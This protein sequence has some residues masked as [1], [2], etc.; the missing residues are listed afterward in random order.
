M[1]D[2]SLHDL[3]E[4][5]MAGEPPIGPVTP[6]A[7]RVGLRLRRRRAA[8]IAGGVVVAAAIALAVPAVTAPSHTVP[9]RPPAGHGPI[10]A[11]MG[12][13]GDRPRQLAFSPDGTILATAD[14]DGTVRLWSVATHRQI[15]R[16]IRAQGQVLSVA[17]SPDG[18][19]LASGDR[20]SVVQLWK[21]AT[22]RQIGAAMYTGEA[23]ITQLAF[24]PD[25]KILATVDELH[26]ALWNVATQRQTGRPIRA[27]V[28]AVAFS[29]DGKLLAGACNENGIIRVWSVA[30]HHRIGTTM[31]AGMTDA[32]GV[33]F[34]PSGKTLV[35]TDTDGTIRQWSVATHHQ[36]RAPIITKGHPPPEFLVAALSPDGTILATTQSDGPA[37]LWNLAAPPQP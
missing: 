32:Y 15:G 31:S 28:L 21:V 17:F 29:P 2:R 27:I 14:T 6:N 33:A 34:T 8:G 18:T 3:L 26:V 25:G 4:D 7:L 37:R 35:T 1:D 16:P 9:D 12:G 19:M 30:T 13:R 22:R 11:G 24:S 10:G 5:A 36:I 20:A 23:D